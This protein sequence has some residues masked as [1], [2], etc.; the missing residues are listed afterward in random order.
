MPVDFASE[1]NISWRVGGLNWG[2]AFSDTMLMKF[3]ISQ[4]QTMRDY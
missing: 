4:F 3:Y 1:A 2:D